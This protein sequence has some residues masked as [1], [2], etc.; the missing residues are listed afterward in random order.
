[1]TQRARVDEWCEQARATGAATRDCDGT[2]FRHTYFYPAEQY[3]RPLIERLAEL[4]AD[5]FGEVEIHLHHGVEQPDTAEN[6]RRALEEF[7][8]LLS[9]EHRCLSRLDGV[10]QP[11]YAFVHGNLAL[12]NSMGGRCCG[13]DSEMRI[14]AETGCYA[15]LTLPAAP[16]QPQAP[17]INALYQCGRPLDEPIPHWTGKN[18]RVGAKITPPVL[19]TG[20]LV[21]DWSRR[22]R[23]LPAPRIDDGA[24]TS[25]YP[26]TPE[27]LR[28]WR[29]AGICVHGRPEWVFI[30]LYCHGFFTNDQAATIGEP[31][32]RFLQETLEL[33]DRDGRFKIHFA[34]ARE[35]FNIALAAVDGHSGEP[36]GYR[37]YR[38]RPI[39]QTAATQPTNGRSHKAIEVKH[40]D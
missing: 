17:R 28:R 20:P 29:G 34:T 21:F 1:A 24:L 18:L 37:N 22:R 23:G 31:A 38:L 14:L 12:A 6:L 9:E 26:L 35:A 4:E 16:L 7:R 13:V 36:G 40:G 10:G 39:R 30:K 15:D 3:H 33:A 25:G 8:D 2:P 5:G 32:R 27:R 19:L 11:R